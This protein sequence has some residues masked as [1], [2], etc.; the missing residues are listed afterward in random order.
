MALIR[1]S[2]TELK[3]RAEQLNQANSNLKAKVE[4]FESAAQAL[5]NQWQGEARD[6]FVAAYSQDKVQMNNF[7]NVINEYYQK[8][9][10]TADLYDRAEQKNVDI[11]TTRNY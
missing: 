5:A 1:V 3:N 7:I 4:E 8:L 9:I 2:A 6:A 10:A 11:A